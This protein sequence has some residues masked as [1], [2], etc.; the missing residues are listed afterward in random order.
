MAHIR[1]SKPD[2]GLGFKSNFLKTLQRVPSSL[3]SG[4]Q[5]MSG[6]WDGGPLSSARGTYKTFLDPGLG[7]QFKV[8]NPFDVPLFARRQ[9]AADA[10]ERVGRG[11]AVERMRHI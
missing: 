3:G 9:S 7:F 6:A 8:L 10:Q 1:Q 5:L 2:S 11:S 4:Q